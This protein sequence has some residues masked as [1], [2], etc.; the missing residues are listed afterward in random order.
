MLSDRNLRAVDALND[1]LTRKPVAFV[2]AGMTRPH[3]VGWTELL[4]QLSAHLGIPLD[5]TLDPIK[6]AEKFY[7]GSRA[8]YEARL[9]AIYGTVPADCRLGLKEL[10]KLNIAGII[11]TNYDY[12]IYRAYMINGIEPACHCYPVLPV[13]LTQRSRNIFFSHGAVEG[14]KISNLDNFILH[15]SAYLKAYFRE[16]APGPG[17]LM[18][19]FFDA[20]NM[21]DVL[22]VG[23]GL[24]RDEPLRLALKAAY[25][26][27]RGGAGKKR[28]M[29]VAAP[30]SDLE[31]ESYK[32]QFGIELV[33]Y[34]PVD[35]SHSGLDEILAH[36]SV[37]RVIS[38]PV[39]GSLLSDF[40]PNLWRT[41]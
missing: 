13:S 15:E 26:S 18:T 40:T 12:S 35:A 25:E 3:F 37:T 4:A 21:N 10:V 41:S 28:L 6:Q 23:Y 8:A 20:F 1:F 14:G 30:V 22:F 29:L 39:F 2:G 5:P 24:G 9:L 27:T 32:Y 33:E 36:V 38:P 19:F 17:V 7:L 34:D 31:R 16:G 11:T